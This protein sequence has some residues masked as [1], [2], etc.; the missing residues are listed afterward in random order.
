[1]HRQA[2]PI[3][4]ISPPIVISILMVKSPKLSK[5]LSYLLVSP[6]TKLH[7]SSGCFLQFF[8]SEK[9]VGKNCAQVCQPLLSELNPYVPVNVL[10]GTLSADNIK[11][12]QV[13][14]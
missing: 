1:M 12:F 13:C 10:E 14:W 7:V 8:F 2:P 4:N 5:V 6:L 11:K 9:D 3:V